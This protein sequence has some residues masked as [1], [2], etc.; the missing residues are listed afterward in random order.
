VLLNI[1]KIN[2]LY[3]L[4]RVLIHWNFA[5]IEKN[6][7]FGGHAFQTANLIH[8]HG[9]LTQ[10][11]LN[12]YIFLNCYGCNF[13]MNATKFVIKYSFIKAAGRSFSLFVA[14]YV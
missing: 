12:L 10:P 8:S 7:F 4:K 13:S 3:I 11:L 6:S 5:R 9:Q 14:I 2:K 1:K